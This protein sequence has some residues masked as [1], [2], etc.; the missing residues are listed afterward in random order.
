MHL[1]PLVA[2][3]SHPKRLGIYVFFT[4]SKTF[5]SVLI[6]TTVCQHA[7]DLKVEIRV[8]LL[9]F[10][11]PIADVV[12]RD[13]LPVFD[14]GVATVLFEQ[15]FSTLNIVVKAREVQRSVALEVLH[16]ETDTLSESQGKV[17]PHCEDVGFKH[18][19]TAKA[20]YT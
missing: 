5:Q 18:P 3:G 2:D 16:V 14:I 8:E 1:S 11:M 4:A 20:H 12:S 9:N 10:W 6:G 17:L 7:I 13:P 19:E 15:Q